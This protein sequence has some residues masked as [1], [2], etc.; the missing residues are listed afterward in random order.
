M[1]GSFYLPPEYEKVRYYQR[2]AAYPPTW[3]KKGNLNPK[4]KEAV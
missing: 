1:R 4:T 2:G 3:L